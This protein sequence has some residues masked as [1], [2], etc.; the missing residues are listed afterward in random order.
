MARVTV[1]RS[2][3][4]PPPP[5]KVTIELDGVEANQLKTLLDRIWDR[6]KGIYGG[7]IFR[8]LGSVTSQ[9]TAELSLQG[10]K[11]IE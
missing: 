11:G 7:S 8:R 5:V 1:E 4:A 10:I 2:E 9:L 3:P 6:D